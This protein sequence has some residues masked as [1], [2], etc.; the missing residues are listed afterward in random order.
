MRGVRVKTISA[1][2]ATLAYG[3]SIAVTDAT[4]TI[5][6]GKLTTIIGPNGSGKS[7]IL[8]GICGLA[9]L[10]SGTIQ[11]DGESTSE[12]LGSIAYVLQATRMNETM[13][14]TVAEVIAM[15]RYAQL[16]RFRWVRAHDRKVCREAAERMNV[17]QLASK[18]I[19][20]LSGGQRQR[21]FVA[22]GLAQEA[23][24]LL[25]DEPANALDVV[26]RQLIDD[27]LRE[28]ISRGTTVAI[29]THD[30]ADAKRADHVILMSGTVVSEG[31]PSVVLDPD[32]LAAA[33]GIALVHLHD[34]GVVIDD[35]GHLDQDR[36]IHFDRTGHATHD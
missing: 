10:R 33:Y 25:L 16:G 26:S 31:L 6:G 17:L 34:H 29:T 24:V 21:V 3:T 19:R 14:V 4:F 28:E 8:N 32:V 30:L 12:H 7:T 35:H 11:I 2:A 18:H 5:P 27:A 9:T 13:P 36:H 23:D 1:T 20:E 15:A 22:Q